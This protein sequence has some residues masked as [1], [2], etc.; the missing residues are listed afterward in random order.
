MATQI[1]QL[2]TTLASPSSNV[3]RAC[4][5]KTQHMSLNG[6]VN[7]SVQLGPGIWRTSVCILA[8]LMVQGEPDSHL[9]PS[10]CWLIRY[11]SHHCRSSV[12][13]RPLSSHLC[14]SFFISSTL[15]RT[16]PKCDRC[17]KIWNLEYRIQLW[18]IVYMYL[19]SYTYMFVFDWGGG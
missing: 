13:N 7:V 17:W 3:Y 1:F 16:F 8:V 2:I 15:E 10:S 5:L 6:V 11:V 12:L 18:K 9:F 14:K 4:F 19:V